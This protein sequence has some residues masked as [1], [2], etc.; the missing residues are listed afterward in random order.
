MRLRSL[1]APDPS[2][3]IVEDELADVDRSGGVARPTGEEAAAVTV[4]VTGLERERSSLLELRL[5]PVG[6]LLMALLLPL[7]LVLLT[8]PP[9]NCSLKKLS[10]LLDALLVLL[11]IG[12]VGPRFL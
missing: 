7:L 12:G 6:G 10:L 1:A 4:V 2:D 9:L 3:E 11:G 5:L 8:L